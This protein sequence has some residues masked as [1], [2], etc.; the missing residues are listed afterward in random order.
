MCHA[1]TKGELEYDLLLL[2][3]RLARSQSRTKNSVVKYTLVKTY[4]KCRFLG[5]GWIE[6]AEGEP[7]GGQQRTVA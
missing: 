3:S 2:R 7:A 5:N 4:G 6:A 1:V